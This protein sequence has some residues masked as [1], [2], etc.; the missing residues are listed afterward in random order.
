MRP[1]NYKKRWIQEDL[2]YLEDS[3]GFISIDTIIKNLKR[4]KGSIE[5]KA[6]ELGLGKS[7]Y[8][9]GLMYSPPQIAKILG[10]CQKEIYK[11]I[12]DGV[13][14]GRRKKLVN[15]RMYQVHIDDL[16]D[17]LKNNPDKWDS[18]KVKEFTFGIEP[19]WMKKKRK[20]DLEIPKA[21]KRWTKDEERYLINYVNLGYEMKDIANLLGRSTKSIYRRSQALR[22]KGKLA[23]TKEMIYWSDEEIKKM[24]KLEQQGLTDKEIAERLGRKDIHITDKRRT[25]RKQGKYEGYKGGNINV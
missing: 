14:K 22:E 25:L 13:L 7:Q 15:E 1:E 4:T 11:L 12:D 2:E 17:F 3:W 19:D 16:M 20:K 6:W 10:K 8:A 23:P 9:D 21:H 18:R 5:R 24:F